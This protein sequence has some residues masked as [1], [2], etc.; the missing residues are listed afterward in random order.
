MRTDQDWELLAEQLL[1]DAI[2]D[3]QA[4]YELGPGEDPAVLRGH[5]RALARQ[6]RM[7][8]RTGII[9]G[10]VAVVLADAALWSQ[11]AHVMRQKLTPADRQP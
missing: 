9:E 7:K 5:V 3:E 2:A 10:V 1:E 8:I 4:V 6:R 11:P